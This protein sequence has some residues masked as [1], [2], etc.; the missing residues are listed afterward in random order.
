LTYSEGL[1]ALMRGEASPIS[2]RAVKGMVDF[3]RLLSKWRLLLDN[4]DLL[5]VFDEIVNDVG[6]HVHLHQISESTEEM[7]DRQNN[8]NELRSL[9]LQNRELP[10]EEFLTEVAL[11]ADVDILK[12]DANAVALLTLHSAKG[13][14]FPVVFIAGVEQGVL[15]HQRSME[16]KDEMAEERR[17]FYVG[18]TR[19]KDQL[20]LTY[21]FRR[22]LYGSEKTRTDISDFLFDIPDNVQE[23][24]SLR[25]KSQREREGYRMETTWESNGTPTPRRAERSK[26]IPFSSSPQPAAQPTKYRAGMSVY[27]QKYGDGTVLESARSGTDEEVTV[28]FKGVGVKRLLAS[29]ANLVILKNR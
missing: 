29:F 3:G 20:Y 11:T 18:L 14:E 5:I 1:A 17:L 2:A 21:T 9:V 25:M 13:L 15:P 23:G 8:V 16:D 7:E 10:L 26:I 22:S 24:M 4:N 27:H 19:A 6:Y 28:V 12:E